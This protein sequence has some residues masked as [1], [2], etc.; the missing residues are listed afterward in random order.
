MDVDVHRF[1]RHGQMQNA[2]GEAADHHALLAGF[3]QGGGKQIAFD[4]AAIENEGFMRAVAARKIANA[5]KAVQHNAVHIA[6]NVLE[7]FQGGQAVDAHHCAFQL[8]VAGAEIHRLAI[9]YIAEGDLRMRQDETQHQIRN[10][11]R[12]GGRLF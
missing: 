11:A 2:H 4:Q 8:A 1:K 7:L 10:I 6:G 3:L 9:G 5:Y 12:F